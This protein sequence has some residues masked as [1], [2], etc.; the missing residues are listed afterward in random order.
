MSRGGTCGT[1]GAKIGVFSRFPTGG[2]LASLLGSP[3]APCMSK[4]V[5]IRISDSQIQ[6]WDFDPVVWEMGQNLSKGLSDSDHLKI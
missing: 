5:M 3:R 4:L 2:G 1:V 6:P